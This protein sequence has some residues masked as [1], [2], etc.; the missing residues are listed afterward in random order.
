MRDSGRTPTV[1]DRL[2]LPG[3][4]TAAVFAMGA[5]ASTGLE[6]LMLAVVAVM[7]TL[8]LLLIRSR[9]TS[10]HGAVRV[11]TAFFGA[12]ATGGGTLGVLAGGWLFFQGGMGILA[13]AVVVPVAAMLTALGWVLFKAGRHSR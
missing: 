6:R 13:G 8:V 7:F 2:I 9:G 4:A 5:I 11:A 1:T 3:F 12:L 10:W